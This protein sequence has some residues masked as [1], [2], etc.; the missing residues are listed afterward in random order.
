MVEA[1][2]E[3]EMVRDE[4]AKK[5]AP[6]PSSRMSSFNRVTTTRRQVVASP[7]QTSRVARSAGAAAGAMAASGRAALRPDNSPGSRERAKASET[8]IPRDSTWRQEP[9][10]ST[11]PAATA[12]RSTTHNYYPGLRSGQHVNANTAKVAHP[13]QTRIGS[14]PGTGLGMAGNKATKVTRPGQTSPRASSSARSSPAPLE[15]GRLVDRLEDE[16]RINQG[17]SRLATVVKSGTASN[18]SVT[19]STK[20]ASCTS[21]FCPPAK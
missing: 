15:R 21:K 7:S 5:P 13:G 9:V 18:G 14:Q 12:V 8:A 19:G 1:D 17:E 20:L 16:Y 4:S 3:D 11:C 6:A 10:G 2:D